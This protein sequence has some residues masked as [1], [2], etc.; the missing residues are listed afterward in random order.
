MK[1]ARFSEEQIITILKEA[2]GGAKVTELCRWHGISD[3]TFY[4]WRSKYGGLEVV[5]DAPAAPARGRESAA[6]VDRGRSG[7]GYSGAQGR[8]G[9]KRLRPAV[10]RAMVVEVMTTHDL[11]QRR[12]CG[13]D[14][15]HATRIEARTGGKSQPR[16]AAT[17]A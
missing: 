16:V 10:K 12:A 9:K 4:T 5:G 6:E 11:S 13:A 8:T 1:R 17:I 7:T 2:E 15:D 3:A 14:R